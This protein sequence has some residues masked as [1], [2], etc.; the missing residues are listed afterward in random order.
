MNDRKQ[1]VWVDHT[2]SDWLDVVLQGSILWPIMFL[3]FAN[4]LPYDSILSSV[5]SSVIGINNQLN[6]D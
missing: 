5:Q 2:M 6:E 3:I 1:A 4:D